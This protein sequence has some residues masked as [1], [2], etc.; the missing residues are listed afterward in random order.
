[1]AVQ[2]RSKK[3]TQLYQDREMIRAIRGGTKTMREA[4]EKYLPREAKENPT[5]YKRRIARSTFANF[6]RETIESHTAKPHAKPYVFTSAKNQELADDYL[7]RSDSKGTS[8]VQ[9]GANAVEDACWNG[10]S[11]ILVDAPESGGRPYFYNLSMDSVLDYDLDEDGLLTYFR[12]AEKITVRDG[13][14]DVKELGR[15][16]VFKREKEVVTWD[17]WEESDG[18]KYSSVTAG[19]KFPLDF[20]P[21]FAVHAGPVAPG[22]FFADPP[23]M[24][25][26]Y[27][28]VQHWQESSDQSHILHV[29]KVPLLFGTGIPEDDEIAIGSEYAIIAPPGSDLKWVEI[30]GASI[31]AG[32]QSI[33]DLESKMMRAGLEMLQNGGATETATGRALRA[34][35]NNNKVAQIASNLEAA[36]EKTMFTIGK[37]NMI[38]EPDFAVSVHKDYGINASTEEIS[39]L[40]Q[41]RTLG[42]LSQEDFLNELKRRSILRPEFNIEDNRDRISAEMV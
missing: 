26:A 31:N 3:M 9:V 11:L 22:E 34:G 27:L 2:D 36:L 40:V 7:K 4:G 13:E 15:V 23:L 1:M 18:G 12:I 42:D 33:V 16:R 38:S 29:A 35:E 21:V 6:M 5:S 19:N 25:L 37:F 24:N 39:A 8:A 10:T 41:A 20:I 30:S 17:L 28:N 14:F 32:R